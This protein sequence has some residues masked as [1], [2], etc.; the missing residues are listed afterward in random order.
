MIKEMTVDDLGKMLRLLKK[1]KLVTGKTK[2]MM[3]SDEEGNNF[4][5]MIMIDG[6]YNIGVPSADDG[7]ILTLYPA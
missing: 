3:S 4:N 6:K 2:V 1:E 5:S 7:D